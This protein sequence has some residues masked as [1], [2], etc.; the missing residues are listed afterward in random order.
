MNF[1]EI[2][3]QSS[4]LPV[5]HTGE[6]LHIVKPPPHNRITLMAFLGIEYKLIKSQKDFKKRTH[7]ASFKNT[8][9]FRGEHQLSEL[10]ANGELSF[11]HHFVKNTGATGKISILNQFCKNKNC[12][13]SIMQ[14]KKKIKKQNKAFKFKCSIN[15]DKF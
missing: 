11:Q 6:I 10:P 5:S 4:S 13:K 8:W 9:C 2:F 1:I 3:R 7:G 15:K 14:H 12:P